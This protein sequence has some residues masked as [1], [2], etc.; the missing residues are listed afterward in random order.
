M[1]WAAKGR[2]LVRQQATLLDLP[3][4]R[5][6]KHTM[7]S[8]SH[9]PGTPTCCCVVLPSYCTHVMRRQQHD[10]ARGRMHDSTASCDNW[11]L[12]R[13]AGAPIGALIVT[14]RWPSSSMNQA[15][16]DPGVRDALKS[17]RPSAAAGPQ[18]CCSQRA[19][20]HWRLVQSLYVEYVR[21]HR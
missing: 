8:F 19:R 17:G 4:S 10:P 15:F 9:L 20:Q 7:K 21:A 18:E 1:T 6:G 16:S 13:D 3:M 14:L 11:L 12:R 5:P 2:T